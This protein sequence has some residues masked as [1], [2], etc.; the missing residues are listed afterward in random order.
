MWEDVAAMTTIGLIGAGHIGSQIARLAVA[1]GYRVVI[2]N[3]GG[4]GTLSGL[5]AELGPNARAATALEAAQCGD[6]SRGHG[7]AEELPRG[8]R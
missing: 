1:C 3:S 6:I 2:S 4:P 8:S 5:V 7:S